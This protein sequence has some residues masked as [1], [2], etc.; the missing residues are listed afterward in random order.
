LKRQH[1]DRLKQLQ[2]QAKPVAAQ[3]LIDRDTSVVFPDRTW[4]NLSI[5]QL[6]R[7]LG[8][9]QVVVG[10]KISRVLYSDRYLNASDA[11]FLSDLLRGDWLESNTQVT[12]HIQQLY[13]EYRSND[14]SRRVT[15][16]KVLT[17]QLGPSTVKIS[18]FI[19]YCLTKEWILWRKLTV[20][21]TLPNLPTWL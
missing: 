2:Q 3:E 10:S 21:I 7:Q 9:E 17:Q 14:T 4:K 8:L 13:E 20:P 1:L 15:L 6:R 19:E 18:R 5:D 16:E 12:I 11:R